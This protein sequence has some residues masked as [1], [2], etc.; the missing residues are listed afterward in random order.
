VRKK[1]YQKDVTCVA[2]Y[3]GKQYLKKLLN[4]R[5]NYTGARSELDDKGILKIAIITFGKRK[6]CFDR[7]NISLGTTIIIMPIKPNPRLK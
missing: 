4:R 6:M 2:N 1:E 3:D 7:C 5:D